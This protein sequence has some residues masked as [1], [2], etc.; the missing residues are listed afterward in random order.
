[1]EVLFFR[2]KTKK[3]IARDHQKIVGC[4]NK[5]AHSTTI[6]TLILPDGLLEHGSRRTRAGYFLRWGSWLQYIHA[7]LVAK[8]PDREDTDRDVDAVARGGTLLLG[9]VLLLVAYLMRE[10]DMGIYE[11]TEREEHI[12]YTHSKQRNIPT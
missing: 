6:I 3:S 2:K 5:A 12:T 11:I 9:K 8:G 4:D 1:M 7:T 10:L